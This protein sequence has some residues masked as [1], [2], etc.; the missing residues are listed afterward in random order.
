MKPNGLSFDAPQPQSE[1][2]LEIDLE[3]FKIN[4]LA[5]LLE[6]DLN[7]N[8]QRLKAAIPVGLL[9]VKTANG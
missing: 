8:L 3:Q 7:D 6:E 1:E 5:A 2:V 4:T 9:E